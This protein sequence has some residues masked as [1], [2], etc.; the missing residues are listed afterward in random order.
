[1]LD[2]NK[3][4][5]L[6]QMWNTLQEMNS[7]I[8]SDVHGMLNVKDPLNRILSKL[9][10]YNA[11]ISIKIELIGQNMEHTLQ[12]LMEFEDSC[13]FGASRTRMLIGHFSGYIMYL[14]CLEKGHHAQKYLG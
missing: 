4:Q 9:K 10:E 5:P 12:Q 2:A 1:M 6:Q 13:D 11:S 8:Q 14:L 7:N 3:Y